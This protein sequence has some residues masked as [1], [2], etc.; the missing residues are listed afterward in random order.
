V[1]RAT[2]RVVLRAEELIVLLVR[3]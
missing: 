2:A 1:N 3:P